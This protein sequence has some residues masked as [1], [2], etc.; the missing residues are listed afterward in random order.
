MIVFEKKTVDL[1]EFGQPPVD[2]WL[3]VVKFQRSFV[4]SEQNQIDVC[5]FVSTCRRLL[6]TLP[7]ILWML[8]DFC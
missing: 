4:G 6:W 2:F 3:I 5:E 1:F 8:V 7:N